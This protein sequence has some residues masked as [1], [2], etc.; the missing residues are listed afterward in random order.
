VKSD[1]NISSEKSWTLW[2]SWKVKD[3]QFVPAHLIKGEGWY[4]IRAQAVHRAIPCL[5]SCKSWTT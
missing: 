1:G 2:T 4:E 5:E 3:G